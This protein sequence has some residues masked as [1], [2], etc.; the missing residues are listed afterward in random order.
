MQAVKQFAK[1]I[2]AP[3]ALICDM[4]HGQTSMNLKKLCP[5]ISTTLRHLDEGTPWT[6]KTELHIVKGDCPMNGSN[7]HLAF[8]IIVLSVERRTPI[9]NLTVHHTF[10]LPG[11]NDHTTLPVEDGDISNLW[12][13]D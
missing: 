12:Q 11:V 10:K 4:S 5:E 9:N 7:S 2:G 3:G 6:N 1:G 13:T 8:W